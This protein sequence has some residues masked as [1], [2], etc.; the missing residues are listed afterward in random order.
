MCRN[1]KPPPLPPAARKAV[2]SAAE[3]QNNTFYLTTLFRFPESERLFIHRT[4]DVFRSVLK[5]VLAAEFV[6]YLHYFFSRFYY[7]VQRIE[8]RTYITPIDARRENV[9]FRFRVERT[10]HYTF[11]IK[12]GKLCWSFDLYRIL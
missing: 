8:Q 6:T 11:I 7:L 9:V 3:T 2:I 1:K 5:L 4:P 12:R 10:P